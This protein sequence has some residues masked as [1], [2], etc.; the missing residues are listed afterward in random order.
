[1]EPV[2]PHFC[3]SFPLGEI[4]SSHRVWTGKITGFSGVGSVGRGGNV[5]TLSNTFFGWDEL[6]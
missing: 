2:K 5:C 3:G 6:A 1:M 4:R